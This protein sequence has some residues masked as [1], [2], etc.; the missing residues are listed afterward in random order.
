MSIKGGYRVIDLSN[1][2][3]M[4]RPQ[5]GEVKNYNFPC[6]L[7]NELKSYNYDK[8]IIVTGLKLLNFNMS[9]DGY[10]H[11]VLQPQSISVGDN[12]IVMEGTYAQNEA[13]ATWRYGVVISYFI[14]IN[15]NGVCTTKFIYKKEVQ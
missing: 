8:P 4:Y 14:S 11:L 2:V 12:Y 7:F 5:W 13:T 6:R 10:D 1:S 15:S 9:G 3:E